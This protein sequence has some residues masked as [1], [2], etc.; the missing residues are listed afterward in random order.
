VAPAMA[1]GDA[2][3]GRRQEALA[4]PVLAGRE[5]EARNV[6]GNRGRAVPGGST[7]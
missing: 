2:A 6:A 1:A 7:G 5:A 4:M 3:G